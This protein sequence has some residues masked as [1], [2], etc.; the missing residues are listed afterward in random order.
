M[1]LGHFAKF[2]DRHGFDVDGLA[3]RRRVELISIHLV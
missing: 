2:L 3:E 1:L